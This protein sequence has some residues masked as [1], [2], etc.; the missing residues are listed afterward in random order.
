[1]PSRVYAFWVLGQLLLGMVGLLVLPALFASFGLKVVYLILAA[2][3]LCCLPLVPAFPQR[4][5]PMSASSRQSPAAAPRRK[6]CAVLAI[7]TFYI[8]LSAVWTFIGTIGSAAGLTAAQIGM[9]LA[10]ATVCGIIGAGGAALRGTRRPDRIPVWLGYGLLILSIVLLVSH[11]LLVR[12]A[13]AALLFK[14]TWTFV[15]PF[16]LA[17][18][19]GLDNNGRLMNSI[20]LVG[21]LLQRFSSADA[22]LAAAGG[23][24]LISAGLILAASSAGKSEPTGG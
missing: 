14:F 19:A 2:I 17:R 9:V 24:A 4:F 3:M 22:L 1:M 11:P 21:A 7:L 20:N 18:V 6:L 13:L 5:Q 15:L 12:F 8:S 16:I 23:C 10:A